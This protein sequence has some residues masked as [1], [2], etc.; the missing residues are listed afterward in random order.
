[1]SHHGQNGVDRDVYA[2]IHPEICLWPTPEWLWEN[3]GGNG[4]S[5][6]VWVTNQVKCWMEH[7]GVKRHY[8]SGKHGDDIII[9]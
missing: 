3:N 4:P 9:E 2:A 6:G 5:S 8:V 7:L 1:M